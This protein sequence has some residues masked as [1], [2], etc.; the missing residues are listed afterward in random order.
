MP[1]IGA[2][3]SSSLREG[4]YKEPSPVYGGYGGRERRR[5]GAGP[6]QSIF[7]RLQTTGAN[8]RRTPALDRRISLFN[9]LRM[10]GANCFRNESA[11]GGCLYRYDPAGLPSTVGTAVLLRGN[12]VGREKPLHRGLKIAPPK[13]LPVRALCESFGR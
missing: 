9:S 13:T 8:R 6:A 5:T 10:T 7:N 1:Q 11:I 3:I 4:F 2:G 12:L